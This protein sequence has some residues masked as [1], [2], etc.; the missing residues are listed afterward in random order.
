MSAPPTLLRRIA[1][2]GNLSATTIAVLASQSLLGPSTRA[3]KING[4]E[5]KRVRDNYAA[6]VALK[7]TMSPRQLR[8]HIKTTKRTLRLNATTP[9]ATADTDEDCS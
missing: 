8:K 5:N 7:S 1:I 2:S 4:T 6:V 9:N 3:N